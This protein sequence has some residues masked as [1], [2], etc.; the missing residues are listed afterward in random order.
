MELNWKDFKEKGWL[1]TD[2]SLNTMQYGKKI[3]SFT[4]H[5]REVDE[6]Y[7]TDEDALLD[8]EN[9]HEDVIDVRNHSEK[10]IQSAVETYGYTL[11]ENYTLSQSGT[12]FSG[13]DGIQ[14][15]AECI[16]ELNH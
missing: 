8:F 3:D 6:K 7:S 14:L 9:W 15:I 5:Y 1:Q 4:W 13:D 10:E 2:G 11:L 16:F 12:V